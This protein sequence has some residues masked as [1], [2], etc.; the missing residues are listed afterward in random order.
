MLQEEIATYGIDWDGPVPSQEW[1]SSSDWEERDIIVPEITM[2]FT[3][4]HFDEQLSHL[5]HAN[6][7]SNFG[8]DVYEQV[9]EFVSDYQE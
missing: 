4:E 5:T 2:P 8:V 1:G 3:N 9:L 6:E 7:S